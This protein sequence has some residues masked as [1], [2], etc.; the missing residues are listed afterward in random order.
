MSL[1]ISNVLDT[2]FKFQDDSL[3]Q[4]QDQ[5]TVSPYLPKRTVLARVSLNF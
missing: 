1:E 3:R 5:S 2:D 4:F